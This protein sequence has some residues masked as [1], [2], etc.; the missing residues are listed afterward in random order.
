M[1]IVSSA[2]NTLEQVLTYLCCRSNVINKRIHESNPAYNQLSAL[3][4]ELQKKVAEYI[5]LLTH[6]SKNTRKRQGRVAGLAKGM[7]ENEG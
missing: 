6:Q 1:K 3:P 4:Y 5:E 7:I 2:L